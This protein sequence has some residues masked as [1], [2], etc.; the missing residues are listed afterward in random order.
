MPRGVLPSRFLILYGSQKGQAQSIADQLADQAAEHGFEADVSCLSQAD[1][2]GHAASFN[3]LYSTFLKTSGLIPVQK[4][5]PLCLSV[6][7]CKYHRR[8]IP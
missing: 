3:I 4:A 1:K 5:C 2:V 8:T 6:T 7:M